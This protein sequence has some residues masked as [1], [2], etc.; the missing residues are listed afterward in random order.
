MLRTTEQHKKI[1]IKASA[2]SVAQYGCTTMRYSLEEVQTLRAAICRVVKGWRTYEAQEMLWVLG[3]R[4][5]YDLK[6]V[7]KINT[8]N[9]AVQKWEDSTQLLSG[10]YGSNTV[11]YK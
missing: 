3:G 7:E 9:I 5:V 2:L 11:Y 6:S 4:D 1:L 10:A 8:N